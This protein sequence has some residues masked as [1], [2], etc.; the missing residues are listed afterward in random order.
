L[1]LRRV[2]DEVI[3]SPVEI[4]WIDVAGRDERIN[5]QGPLA[6]GSQLVELLLFNDDVLALLILV[7]R[8]KSEK[9]Y[10]FFGN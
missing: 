4:D 10:N 6:F 5:R 3:H 1:R 2:G 7:A 9:F 8:G